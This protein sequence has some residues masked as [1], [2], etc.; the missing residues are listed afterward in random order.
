[1]ESR[2]AIV[3]RTFIKIGLQKKVWGVV[4]SL[5]DDKRVV[6]S[7]VATIIIKPISISRCSGI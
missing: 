1:M 5:Q 2:G 4:A 7:I 6:L 3:V